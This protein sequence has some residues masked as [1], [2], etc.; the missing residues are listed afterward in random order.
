M[1]SRQRSVQLLS[2]LG[3]GSQLAAV[4]LLISF[5]LGLT[6]LLIASWGQ[7]EAF[8]LK[9][10]G[11]FSRDDAFE[12]LNGIAVIA[13]AVFSVLV[14]IAMATTR[15]GRPDVLA[16]LMIG[17]VIA[18]SIVLIDQHWT[19]PNWFVIVA[20]CSIGSLVGSVVGVA[21]WVLRHQGPPRSPDG[22]PPE[23]ST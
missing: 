6:G 23:T 20:V 12:H 4:A 13:W 16:V 19:D 8:L 21:Y 10:F 9:T 11:R 2:R 15:Y 1:E 14:L 22:V 3:S 7:P 17:P 5:W 18:A